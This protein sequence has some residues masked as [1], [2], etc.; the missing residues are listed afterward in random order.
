VVVF[1][2]TKGTYLISAILPNWFQ[3]LNGM[4]GKASNRMLQITHQVVT[5]WLISGWGSIGG[6]WFHQKSDRQRLVHLADDSNQLRTLVQRI[7]IGLEI[8]YW[9]IVF[10]VMR[11][12]CGW[13]PCLTHCRGCRPRVGTSN[14]SEGRWIEETEQIRIFGK[15]FRGKDCRR[16][17]CRGEGPPGGRTAGGVRTPRPHSLYSGRRVWGCRGYRL[18][19]SGEVV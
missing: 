12:V 15:D 8:V 4:R 13:R 7:D 6:N 2:V 19:F 9:L 17:D 14:F 18:A 10:R 5:G 11:E 16:K 3:N 1:S